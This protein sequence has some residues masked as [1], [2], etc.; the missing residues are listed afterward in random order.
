MKSNQ[1]RLAAC[2]V[3]LAALL[4]FAFAP[5]TV[6]TQ[7]SFV[8]SAPKETRRAIVISLDGLDARYIRRADEYGLKIPTLRRLARE[9]FF[10]GVE[11]VYPS[12][13]YPNHTTMVT[14]A[15]PVRHGVLNNGIFVP[16]NTP[17]T[18]SWY[19][20]A[21][22]V[23]ADALWD[24]AHR[25]K[26][27]TALVSWPVSTGA[28]DWNVPEIW[29]PGTAPGD[30]FKTTLAEISKHARPAGLVEEIER[31]D[32]EIY[33][34][35]TKDEG[36]DMRTRWAEYLIREKRPELVLVHLFDLD[37]YE[38][39]KGPFTP[40]AFAILE[41]LDGYVA[42]IIAAAERAGTLKETVVFIT[43]DHGFRPVLK[44]I[45]P[46]VILS[47]AGLA[48]V[49]EEKDET[50]RV[51]AVVSDWT[52]APHPAGGSCGIILR[53]PKDR[54]AERR[55]RAALEDYN[56]RSGGGLYRIVPAEETHKLGAFPHAAFVLEAAAGYHFSHQFHG[57]PISDS[58]GRGTHGYLPAPEDY[59]ATFIG[60]G[61]DVIKQGDM[62]T[63]HMTEVGPTIASTLDIKLRDAQARALTIK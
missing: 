35:V 45:R 50:G 39:D 51:K 62:G 49:H 18:N 10:A 59:R 46:G 13:T 8:S 55:T 63:I 57:E 54:A 24:A 15:L 34:N 58:Y 19:W 30:D 2:I 33:K 53:D 52:A 28:A 17:Q 12:V 31:A 40:E 36:D 37:H 27:K 61:L 29:K 20:F 21:H 44:Q 38:H 41:K 23:K 48:T 3:A 11:S 6:D 22:Q 32:P 56:R 60:F 42:R 26:L 16:P 9:G 7:R 4:H 47:R 5:R 1:S 14:G 43:S 25:K